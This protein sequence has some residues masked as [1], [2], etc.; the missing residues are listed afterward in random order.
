MKFFANKNAI[1]MVI[2]SILVLTIS[3][4]M[5][6]TPTA[7]AHTPVWNIPSFAYISV[8]PSPV[9]VGQTAQVYLWVDIPM[10]SAALT[11][12]I[13]R[14]GYQLTITNPDGTIQTQSWDIISDTTGIQFSSFTPDKIGT[15]TFT[16]NYTGQTY[17]WSGA[18]QNDIML[19]ASAS[20]T[21]EVTD[22]LLPAPI[23]SYPLPTEY[24]TRPIEGQN[25]DWYRISSNWLNAP[26][27]RSGATSTGGA[28]Y[29]R[30]QPDGTGPNSP[31]VMWSKELQFGGIV[32]GNNTTVSGET[33]YM[34]GS[35]NVRFSNA[36]V[37]QGNLYYQE[38]YGNGGGGG[39]YVAVDIRTGE[40]LWRIN[41]SRTGTSLFPTFAYLPSFDTGNQHG[42]LPNGLLINQRSVTGLGNVWSTYDPR[43]GVLTAMNVTNVPSGTASA[44]TL[45]PSS[46]SSVSVA[47]PNGEL[48][49]YTL[50]NSGTTSNVQM[51]L[52]QWNSSKVINA[53]SGWYSGTVN[54]SL[55]SRYDWNVSVSA[56]NQ[57]GG[58]WNIYRDAYFNDIIL[59]LQGS[60]GTGPRTNP[61]GVN[62]TAI[63]INQA[64]HGR[65]LWSKSYQQAPNN[66]TA[67]IIAVDNIARTFIVEYKETMTLTGYSLTD[68][69][70]LWTT[71]PD[72][73]LWDTMRSVTLSAYGNLYRS[74]FD[75]ILYCYD[76][77]TGELLWT[78]GN[79]GTGN[80][81]YEGLGTSYG[82]MPIFVDVI[83]DGKVYLG[84]TEHSPGSPW[85]K[86]STYRCINATDGTE[87]WQLTGWGTGMYVGQYDIVADGYFLYL[88][89]Y[90][91]KV[92]SVG[93][94]PSAMT[95]TASPKVS[96][97][98]SSVI[99]E[100]TVTDIAAGTKQDEQVARFPYGVPAVSDA[101]QKAWM[102]YVY[103]QK[104]RPTDTVGVPVTLSVVDSNGNYR[105]IGQA[106]SDADGF[107]SLNWKPDIE[108]RY[109]VYASFGG[110]ESY[111]P[112]HAVTSFAVDSAAP[113]PT[114][115]EAPAQSTTDMYFV[116]AVAGIIVAIVICFAI[117]ILL[118]RKRP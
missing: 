91:L 14:R 45:A 97:Y 32:G 23:F 92:Y 10:P 89:C 64:D 107:Y 20:A 76:D 47:G 115:T 103:M 51:Y 70:Q 56:L 116:P 41:A 37:V 50:A 43:T 53:D 28:G 18:Y 74:G 19:P 17:T 106:T 12:D 7:N 2:A 69:S 111:W 13:R 1:A 46:A 99:I 55:A 101:S 88:N 6:L 108:G 112:S 79:G 63:S 62:V 94:G 105:E 80:S 16:F 65:V 30:Y 38:S 26:W 73:A 85:Y 15:Y 98:G 72:I 95:L 75:G 52:N 22:T 86:D 82:H 84:T 59:C 5:L 71:T 39:D 33:Y 109:T 118:L 36:M 9:G 49:I 104:P 61:T 60:F 102:E 81:T 35:Y 113:T 114:P 42:I 68:G 4:Q 48:L 77:A 110:S 90:D 29:G 54:A 21:L 3:S 58:A 8:V 27:I 93:K 34:G 11:N 31:H 25:T 117:T 57:G 96:T 40:E 83:A 24:W 44:A 78:Y 66:Q 87:I 100:G 67:Q